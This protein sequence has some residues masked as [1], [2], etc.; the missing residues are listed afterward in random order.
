MALSMLALFLDRGYPNIYGQC[1]TQV[2]Y[3]H[4]LLLLSRYLVLTNWFHPFSGD[5]NYTD[6][7]AVFPDK[8]I[9]HMCCLRT[10]VVTACMWVCT[11]LRYEAEKDTHPLAHL[12]V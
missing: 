11:N 9:I 4:L 1:H 7:L 5:H 2:M 8:F 10:D 3:I 6:L 12:H